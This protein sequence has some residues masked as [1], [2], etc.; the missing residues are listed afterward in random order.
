MQILITA[1]IVVVP[2]VAWCIWIFPIKGMRVVEPEANP[3]APTRFRQFAHWISFKERRVANVV[4]RNCRGIHC[5]AI[6]ML[7]GDDH[8]LHSRTF[9]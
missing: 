9:D 5:K 2:V 8:V 7:G 4:L 3:V 1:G 6:V